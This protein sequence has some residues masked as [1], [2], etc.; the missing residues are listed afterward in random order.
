MYDK[1][2]KEI[3][4]ALTWT[5]ISANGLQALNICKIFVTKS[6]FSRKGRRVKMYFLVQK[7]NR[8]F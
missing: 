5:T 8:A 1:I 6:E 7:W 4:R 3:F 2:P